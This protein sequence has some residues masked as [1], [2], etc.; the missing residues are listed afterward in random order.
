MDA[1]VL[2]RNTQYNVKKLVRVQLRAPRMIAAD[3]WRWE[4][5]AAWFGK[6]MEIEINPPQ[7]VTGELYIHFA[8]WNNEGRDAGIWLEGREFRTGKFR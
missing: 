1:S 7:G 2:K 6:E 8:D 5:K 4:E 3:I